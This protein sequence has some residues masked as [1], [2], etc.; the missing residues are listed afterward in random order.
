[1][2]S[3]NKPD[4]NQKSYVLT[5]VG[6]VASLLLFLAIMLLAYLPNRPDSVNAQIVEER[7]RKFN[8]MDAKQ[9]ALKDQYSWVDQKSGVVRIPVKR[10]MELTVQRLA[11]GQKS[12][13]H[14][15]HQFP[16]VP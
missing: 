14:G 7:T 10:A 8:E 13:S 9:Q 5:V 4:I 16:E 11:Q 15:D 12:A 6:V 3:E 2:N 1:M